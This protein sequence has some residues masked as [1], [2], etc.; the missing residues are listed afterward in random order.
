MNLHVIQK[1]SNIAPHSENN[2]I[3]LHNNLI[4]NNIEQFP[5]QFNKHECPSQIHSPDMR[6]HGF[7]SML[8]QGFSRTFRI[9]RKPVKISKEM[10][11]EMITKRQPS[12]KN[13]RKFIKYVEMVMLVL[14][15]IKLF[16]WRSNKLRNLSFVNERQIRLINDPSHMEQLISAKGK[17]FFIKNKFIRMKILALK[18]KFKQF[19]VYSSKKKKI[20]KFFH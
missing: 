4:I 1:C 2:E 20:Y 7:F 13:T 17:F 10:M 3:L 5:T 15:A 18:K 6:K 8:K 11:K 9:F 16:K 14:K 12:T 19:L